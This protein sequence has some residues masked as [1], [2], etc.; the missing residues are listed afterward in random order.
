MYINASSGNLLL[1]K[2][3]LILQWVAGEISRFVTKENYISNQQSAGARISRRKS[4]RRS[5]GGYHTLRTFP[6]HE[7]LA[8]GMLSPQVGV[9]TACRWARGQARN[10]C[11]RHYKLRRIVCSISRT[12]TGCFLWIM[13]SRLRSKKVTFSFNKARSQRCCS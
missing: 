8:S 13:P 10:S 3:V 7:R 11:L 4:L 5:G 9:K 2:C 6:M 12:M 1:T